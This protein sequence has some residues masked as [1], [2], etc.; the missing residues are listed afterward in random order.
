[1]IFSYW[2]R[3]GTTA[4]ILDEMLLTE[5]AMAKREIII[6]PT[7]VKS[8]SS[9]KLCVPNFLDNATSSCT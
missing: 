9:I 6:L 5:A 1:M 2:G 8:E 4:R 7:R 3:I